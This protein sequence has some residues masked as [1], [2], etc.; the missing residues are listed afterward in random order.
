MD[1]QKTVTEFVEIFTKDKSLKEKFQK[2]P[3]GTV[4]G[5]IKEV[6]ITDQQINDIV[7]AVKTKLK[8][9]DSKDILGGIKKLFS[10]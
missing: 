7:T 5:L 4:K 8:L 6:G 9:D 1:I 2:D 3:I 10:K